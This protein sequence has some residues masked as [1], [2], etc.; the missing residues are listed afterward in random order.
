MYAIF[1]KKNKNF[2]HFARMPQENESVINDFIYYQILWLF[3][4]ESCENVMNLIIFVI[5]Y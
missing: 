5:C 1:I 2:L 4:V 3:I